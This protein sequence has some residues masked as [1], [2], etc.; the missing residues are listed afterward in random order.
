MFEVFR[1]CNKES[2]SRYK[3]KLKTLEA[4]TCPILDAGCH[5]ISVFNEDMNL[6]RKIKST[7]LKKGGLKKVGFLRLSPLY[8]CM[9]H[10]ATS[11]LFETAG[12]G[13]DKSLN[14]WKLQVE[15]DAKIEMSIMSDL[16][17]AIKEGGDCASTRARRETQ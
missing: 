10:E 6:I 13:F 5:L 3:K 14:E 11:N 16:E 9:G 15:K 2:L 8:I 12:K 4:L 7:I 1:M 17:T